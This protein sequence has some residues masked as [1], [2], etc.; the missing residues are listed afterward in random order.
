MVVAALSAAHWHMLARKQIDRPL[1][2][3]LVTLLMHTLHGDYVQL[4]TAL[5]TF[6]NLAWPPR[7]AAAAGC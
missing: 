3:P 2:T 4:A 5:H 1:R 6:V 7:A